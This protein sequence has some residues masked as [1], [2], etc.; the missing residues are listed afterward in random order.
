MGPLEPYK[1]VSKVIITPIN[2]RI[3]GYLGYNDPYKLE[4][5]LPIDRRL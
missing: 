4:W 5:K 2:G 1:W 3:T